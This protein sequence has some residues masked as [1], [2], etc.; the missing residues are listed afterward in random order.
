[1]GGTSNLSVVR[2][3]TPEQVRADV[4]AKRAAGVD[5]IGPEC[6]V[7]LDAPW[8]NMVALAAE[9]KQGNC[10]TDAHR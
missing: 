9:V 3:G 10:A 1:M 5:I 7:P 8:R 4:R 2:S 6:A